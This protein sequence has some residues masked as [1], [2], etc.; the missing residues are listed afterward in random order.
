[1]RTFRSRIET[2]KQDYYLPRATRP[3]LPVVKRSLIHPVDTLAFQIPT[4]TFQT[5]IPVWA[6]LVAKSKSGL[7]LR[8]GVHT[9]S[10]NTVLS[11]LNRKT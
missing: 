3:G 11:L 8:G 5:R 9:T 7:R 2:V 1:M 6:R 10:H 4:Q